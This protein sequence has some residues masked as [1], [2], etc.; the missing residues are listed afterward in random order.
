MCSALRFCLSV[1]FDLSPRGMVDF[2]RCRVRATRG[3]RRKC[4]AEPPRGPPGGLGF[5]SSSHAPTARCDMT[6]DPKT[7]DRS[8]PNSAD[9]G[10]PPANDPGGAHA[11]GY[12]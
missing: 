4:G 8:S 1:Y 12:S 5:A 11:K 10:L 3:T 9:P 6:P 7:T 2:L